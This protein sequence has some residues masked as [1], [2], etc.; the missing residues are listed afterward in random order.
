M[1]EGTVVNVT[2]KTGA[3]SGLG[4]GRK[5]NMSGMSG[6]GG[7]GGKGDVYSV[8]TSNILFI[9]SGAFIGLDKVVLDRVAKGSIG[10]G[11]TLRSMDPFAKSLPSFFSSNEYIHALDHVEPIDLI[12]YG[13]IPEF[14]GR[15]P[16]VASVNH[17][18]VED[19]VRVLTEPRSSLVK[20]YEGLFSLSGVDIKFTRNAL[21]AIA[22]QAI[23]KQTGARGLRRIMES[24]LLDP[25]FDSPGS[26][27]RYIV[28]DRDVVLRKKA[29]MYFSRGDDGHVARAIS[30]DIDEPA[31]DCVDAQENNRVG[32][33]DDF[34]LPREVD[35]H[36]QLAGR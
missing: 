12:K 1:L 29:P 8:D 15:L 10:F 22:E 24:L 7:I 33:G 28:I 26:S 25:M 21:K 11:A 27:I 5:N 2:D 19:L 20:Q 23:E 6:A 36:Q 14:V 31:S 34:N 18:T 13:L 3:G 32:F 16:V 9:L 30:D 35:S 4:G 17:L